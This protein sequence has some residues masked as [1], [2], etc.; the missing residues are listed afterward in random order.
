M[1]PRRSM[2]TI[3]AAL[4]GVSSAWGGAPSSL[5]GLARTVMGAGQGVYVEAADGA[6]LVSQAADVA[7]HPASVSK[8]P[9]TLALLR[10]FGGEHRFVTVFASDGRVREDG[11]L[12]GDLIVEAGG[13]PYF[14]DENAL[15]VAERLQQ[16]GV[17]RVAGQLLVRGAFTFDWN[18]D[19]EGVHLRQV[20]SGRA[21]AAAWAAVHALDAPGPEG[22][23]IELAGLPPM[24]ALQFAAAAGP[25]LAGS[26]IAAAAGQRSAESLV[27]ESRPVGV[28]REQTLVVHRSQPLLSL[29][30]SLNDY[31]NNIFTPLAEAAGGA[32]EVEA[33]ARSAVA[34][35][36]RVEI[37]LGDGAGMDPSNR[38]SPRAVVAL[39]R[40]LER[41][42]AASGHT[43]T[44]ILP[45]AGIDEGTLHLRLNAAD[46]AGRVVGKTGTFGDYGASA[47]VGA[48]VTRDRGE[49]YFALLNHGVPVP[50]ARHRQD[51]FVAALLARLHARRWDY[52]RDAHPAVA[53]ASAQIVAPSGAAH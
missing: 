40:V 53:L 10:K 15:L 2:A 9:T 35:A 21:P 23:E 8:I 11:T 37:T 49:V 46:E 22:A 30:K 25:L 20:L 4:L 17:R 28:G 26:V 24:P 38:M 18:R 29:V 44:D 1:N 13:D 43:L 12:D 27:S 36:M 45:V 52:Q 16:L 6:V 50:L 33:L 7:V 34:P 3:C 42:L 39:L 32:S 51:R 14:V 31:S 48:F 19:D 5:A 47:L 41:E